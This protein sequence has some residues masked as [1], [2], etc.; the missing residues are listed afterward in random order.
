MTTGYIAAVAADP[1]SRLRKQ[2][3]KDIHVG[4]IPEGSTESVHAVRLRQEPGIGLLTIV[5]L[6]PDTFLTFFCDRQWSLNTRTLGYRNMQK[7]EVQ[8]PW[9]SA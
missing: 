1:I 4:V 7:Q 8:G 5:Q 3:P 6:S 2:S 9:R